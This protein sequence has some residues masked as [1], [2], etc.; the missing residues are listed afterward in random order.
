[1]PPDPPIVGHVL[2]VRM[3]PPPQLFTCSAAPEA[4]LTLTI[5]VC[6]SNVSLM[7]AHDYVTPSLGSKRKRA[8]Q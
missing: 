4:F 8:W 2:H 1:M 3:P 5:T 7:A 6:L